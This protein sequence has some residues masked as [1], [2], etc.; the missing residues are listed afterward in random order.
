MNDTINLPER[1]LI[2]QKNEITEHHIYNRLA[3]STKSIENKKILQSIAGDELRHYRVWEK[4]TGKSVAPSWLK[5]FAYYWLGKL[6]GLTFAIKLMERGEAETQEMYELL[7]GEI[8]GAEHIIHEENEHEKALIGLLD[9]ERLQYM[10]SIVLGLNDAL[11]ELTGSLAGLTLA[12]RN[13]KL[14]ALSGLIVGIAAA[15]S[16]A[17]SEYLSTKAEKSKR[18]PL[19]SSIYTGLAYIATVLL[20]IAPYLIF[21]DSFVSLALTLVTAVLIIAGFNYYISVAKDESFV[22]QFGEMVVISLSVAAV[23]FGLGHLLRLFFGVEI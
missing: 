4:H 3:A 1:L 10:G 5:V 23:S 6:L 13:T 15:L 9:E 14:V 19:R 12:L 22:G 17:A 2:F 11:V 20:L 7:H 8:D 16:M 21:T 18:I